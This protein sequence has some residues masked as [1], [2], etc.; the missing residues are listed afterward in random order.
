MCFTQ[1]RWNCNLHG[2]KKGKVFL[3]HWKHIFV[4]LWIINCLQWLISLS[5]IFYMIFFRW[6]NATKTLVKSFAQL[7]L[8]QNDRTYY[9]VL[10]TQ[11]CLFVKYVL[12]TQLIYPILYI[13]LIRSNIIIWIDTKQLLYCVHAQMRVSNP[14]SL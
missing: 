14:G 4:Y 9:K 1:I 3:K 8:R 5:Q 2:K 10:Q 7:I 13:A 6:S 12:F 11:F